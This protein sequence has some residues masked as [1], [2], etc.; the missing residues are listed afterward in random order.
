MLQTKTN[1]LTKCETTPSV[2]FSSW[3]TGNDK[4]MLKCVRNYI[5]L[6]VKLEYN[7]KFVSHNIE[8][9]TFISV[10]HKII[11]RKK[12]YGYFFRN[13]KFI[14]INIH[15]KFLVIFIPHYPLS[16]LPSKK[17]LHFLLSVLPLPSLPLLTLLLLTSL[18]YLMFV[19]FDPL[20]LIIAACRK[21]E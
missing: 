4:D 16:S 5:F 21:N 10:P 7:W 20:T 15:T 14:N 11:Y 17:L 12:F 3:Y 19:M 13:D 1:I 2:Q 6:N 9:V 8:T 18:Y